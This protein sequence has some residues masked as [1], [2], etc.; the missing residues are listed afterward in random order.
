MLGENHNMN[1]LTSGKNTQVGGTGFMPSSF[2][3]PTG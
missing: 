2:W 1:L 3:T